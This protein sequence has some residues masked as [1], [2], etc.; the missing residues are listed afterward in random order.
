MARSPSSSPSRAPEHNPCTRRGSASTR[1]GRGRAPA[2]PAPGPRGGPRPASPGAPAGTPRAALP[3]SAAASTSR[4]LCESL[5]SWFQDGSSARPGRAPRINLRWRRL[6]A[7]PGGSSAGSARRRGK[8][9]GPEA[10]RGQRSRSGLGRT[11]PLR[12]RRQAAAWAVRSASAPSARALPAPGPAGPR[13][14]PRRVLFGPWGEPARRCAAGGS[15]WRRWGAAGARVGGWAL[16]PAASPPDLPGGRGRGTR[17]GK[18]G[19][20]GPPGGRYQWGGGSAGPAPGAF[21]SSPQHDH[22]D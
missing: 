1:R 15:L 17:A 10:G 22:A 6:P 7:A 18:G 3:V 20:G 8:R 12:P 21:R 16:S 13:P 11:A 19:A 5:R 9:G 4:A 2:R 14:R